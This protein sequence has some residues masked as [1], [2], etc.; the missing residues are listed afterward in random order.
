MNSL[1]YLNKQYIRNNQYCELPETNTR[2]VRFRRS[3]GVLGTKRMCL[4][5]LPWRVPRVL[6]LI[7]SICSL[8]NLD[9]SRAL[10]RHFTYLRFFLSP[11]L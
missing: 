3:H 6:S 1:Q 7:E 11:S 4:L 9:H 10:F 5:R 2:H 8:S